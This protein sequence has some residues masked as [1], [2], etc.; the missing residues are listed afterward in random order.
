MRALLDPR[1][2]GSIPDHWPSVCTI[3]AVTYTTNDDNQTIP[4]GVVAVEG[5]VDI[6]CRIGPIIKERPT[7][8]EIR[9]QDIYSDFTRRYLKL[10]KYCPEIMERIQQAV[11]DDVTYEI[12]GVEHDSERFSTRLRLEIIEPNG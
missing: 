12:R 9:T 10:N 5:L 8:D 1:L 2:R 11:V 4:S 3:L 6:P 7:D